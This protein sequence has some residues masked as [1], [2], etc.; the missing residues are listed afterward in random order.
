[1]KYNI[2]ITIKNNNN[3]YKNIIYIY[4]KYPFQFKKNNVAYLYGSADFK[5]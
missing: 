2:Q 5:L 1:M 3:N 4:I